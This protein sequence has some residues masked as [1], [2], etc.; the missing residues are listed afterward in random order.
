MGITLIRLFVYLLGILPVILMPLPA[1]AAAGDETTVGSISVVPTIECIGVVVSYSGDNNQNNNAI[2]Q[3]RAV[4]SAVW[5]DTFPLYVD[6][7]DRQWRGSMFWL[8]AGTAY[9][10]RVTFTDSDGV[11]SSA[12]VSA[13]VTTRPDEPPQS[14]PGDSFYVATSGSDSTG[15]G[16]IGSPWRTIQ[17]AVNHSGPGDTVYIRAGT[18]EE[19][20]NVGVSGTATNYIIIRNY[21]NES[22]TVTGSAVR[23]SVF[24]STGRD[25]VAIKG[26]TIRSSLSY[27]VWL[28]NCDYWFIED[29][30]FLDDSKNGSVTFAAT[31]MYRDGGLGC[32]F[33]RNAVHVDNSW[34]VN[35]VCGFLTYNNPGA[36]IVRDSTFDSAVGDG[37]AR[38][39]YLRDAAYSSGPENTRGSLQDADVYNNVINN[40]SDEG[41]QFDGSGV[42]CRAWNNQITHTFRALGSCPCLEG[43]TYYIRNRV[44]NGANGTKLGDSDSASNSGRVYWIHNSFSL[45]GDIYS[46]GNSGEY[47]NFYCRNNAALSGRYLW[48]ADVDQPM[49]NL[50]YECL[51]TTDTGRFMQLDSVRYYNL[52]AVQAVYPTLFRNSLIPANPLFA[53][54]L[55]LSLQAGSPCIDRAEILVQMNDAN[56]P[57]PYTGNAPDIGANEYA[58]SPPPSNNPPVLDPIGNRTV[59]AGSQLQFTVSA[60]D[61][62]DTNLTYSASNLPSGATFN[63]STHMFSWSPTTGQV[64]TYPNV[65]FEVNDG[66]LSD[67]ED[68]SIIVN[69]TTLIGDVS[70]DGA[71]NIL[72]MIRIGQHWGETGTAGWIP[73]DVNTDGA[74]NTLDNIVVGQHWTG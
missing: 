38:T 48:D 65:H 36:N 28:S 74:I 46:Y 44:Y 29:C 7:A 49:S 41:I 1:L 26:L 35:S 20:V 53:G 14:S 12:T 72:D 21:S 67:F 51:H 42:N 40:A 52:S 22:V 8:T 43:P 19:Q 31:V 56:S 30:T 71:V 32:T 54:P 37:A 66:M 18:Y 47:G 23:A 3:Y 33:Q 62:D 64:G 57:W 10:V 13:S 63:A 9:E 69:S 55:D 45:A 2:M 5:K 39:S 27:C 68:I 24:T 73:E 17:N 60:S 25:Y 16:S 4:G 70:Q 6:R 61:P 59:T 15:N 58:S 50:D 11:G 34:T